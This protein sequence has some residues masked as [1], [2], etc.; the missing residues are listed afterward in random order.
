MKLLLRKVHVLDPGSPHHDQLCDILI[1]NGIVVSI[2]KPGKLSA[3]DAET[4]EG[5][6]RYV[7]TGWFDLH[8][9]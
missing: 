1:E 5:D 6:S 3:T 7:S 4:V 9:H 8:V 2:E